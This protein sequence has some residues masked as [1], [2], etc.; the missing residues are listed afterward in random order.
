MCN[1]EIGQQL[2]YPQEIAE[3]FNSCFS[4]LITNIDTSSPNIPRPTNQTLSSI[5][6]S[7]EKIKKSLAF[8][9]P[10]YRSYSHGVPPVLFRFHKPDLA[11]FLNLFTNSV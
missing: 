3:F 5:L 9:K 4:T 2:D 6:F 10:S 11:P 8:V 7:T 1:V